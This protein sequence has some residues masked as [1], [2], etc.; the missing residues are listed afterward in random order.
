MIIGGKSVTLKEGRLIFQS[1]E[2][3][4]QLRR[5]ITTDESIRTAF[6]QIEGF[7]SS[8]AAFD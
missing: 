3:A 1:T 8:D 4:E 5:L 7:V 2:D 6:V